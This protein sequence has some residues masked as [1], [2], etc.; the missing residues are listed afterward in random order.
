M[1][2][3]RQ[4]ERA[5][6]DRTGTHPGGGAGS[7]T[8]WLMA[9]SAV[10]VVVIAVSAW[11]LPASAPIG[12]DGL[13]FWGV[14]LLFAACEVGA[15]QLRSRRATDSSSL[16]DLAVVLGLLIATPPDLLLGQLAGAAI[17]F[18]WRRRSVDLVVRQ[19]R[20]AV[21][22]GVAL[23]VFAALLPDAPVVG[24]SLW[25][26]ALAAALAAAVTRR[27]LFFLGA[28]V[29]A[30]NMTRA[31][32]STALG[33]D[34]V[35][36]GTVGC[37]GLAVFTLLM[38]EA[39]VWL[40]VLPAG[41][42]LV[43]YRAYL[44]ERHSHQRLAFLYGATDVLLLST[45]V[46][47]ALT[48]LM[49]R[50][51]VALR[52]GI[53]EAVLLP[54]AVGVPQRTRSTQAVPIS[55]EPVEADFVA[56]LT[57]LA[58]TVKGAR[59]LQ[60]PVH[61]ARLERYLRR[62]GADGPVIVAALDGDPH[63]LGLLLVANRC[64]VDRQF[65]ES[66]VELLDKLA[67]HVAASL[68]HEVL[69][70]DFGRLEQLQGQ[71]EHIAFHDPLTS[72]VN[73]ARFGEQLSHALRRRDTLVA[74]LFIDLDDFKTVNDSLG[75]RAGDELLVAVAD[76]L[77]LSLRVYDTPARLGGDEFAVLID[78]AESM[79]VVIEIA[80]RVLASLSDPFKVAAT[81]IFV[82]ASIGVATSHEGGRR[83]EDLLR[84]ADLAMYRAKDLGKG[85]FELFEPEMHALA[86]HRHELKSELQRAVEEDQLVVL[87]QPVVDLPTGAITGVEALVRWQH[88][89]LGLVSPDAFIPLA[90]ESG[91]IGPI[92]RHVFDQA[93][94]RLAAWRAASIA[95]ESFT[96]SINLSVR[97]FQAP[98]LVRVMTETADRAGVPTSAITL[99]I[100]ESA[101]MDDLDAGIARMNLIKAAGFGLALDDFGTGYSSLSHLRRLPIDVLKVAKPFV[102]H[103]AEREEDVAFLRS[104]LDF[105][106]TLSLDV[107]VEGVESAQQARILLELG[108]RRVQGFVFSR[109]V[110]PRVL[111]ALLT[112]TPLEGFGDEEAVTPDS[113]EGSARAEISE[114]AR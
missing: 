70:E 77:R 16:V 99:E 24:L 47:E 12:T 59:L 56:A 87:F 1:E 114:A 107:V 34:I 32:F 25:I 6:V 10:V 7:R 33:R 74:A 72:L 83:T 60:R 45:D 61:D 69:Q 26:P 78:D 29:V 67:G 30:G 110:E 108:A 101:L 113:L 5:G 40:I 20:T 94:E 46:R 82:R 58:G 42:G 31:E 8:I 76:R 39:S 54:P 37:I 80:E 112:V 55:G 13:P 14:A 18:A 105:A 111:S 85:R 51:R 3:G 62:I 93:C 100:T 57:A 73:R 65:G 68:G 17:V 91:L 109:P 97:E 50:T 98:D 92:G 48:V 49:G 2:P 90:E 43:T 66:E 38:L 75:H 86:M 9:F 23:A 102:D 21:A 44:V 106:Q 79:D 53:A 19:A 84:N 41:A 103:I 4:T 89:R 36:T 81:E 35:L 96:V 15:V 52:A 28:R 63:P 22:T 88:P 27:A 104:I 11:L 64:E 95:G 71:L